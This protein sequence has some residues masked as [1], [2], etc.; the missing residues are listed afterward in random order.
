MNNDLE[1]NVEFS[2]VND[3]IESESDNNMEE[4]ETI[5]CDNCGE[6]VDINDTYELP[7]GERICQECYDNDYFTCDRCGE[8][9]HNDECNSIDSGNEYV[10]NDCLDNYYFCEDCQEY[11]SD[12]TWVAS[13][14]G[15]GYY[16]CDHCF[17]N[18]YYYYCE[19]CGNYYHEDD[20]EYDEDGDRYYCSTCY[21]QMCESS[22]SGMVMNY[23]AHKGMYARNILSKP[24]E[25]GILDT[26]YT[27]GTETEMENKDHTRDNESELLEVLGGCGLKPVFERDGSL[28]S[29]GVEM[30][31]MPYT[32][33]YLMEHTEDIKNAFT[34]AIELG[35]RADNDNCG[36]HI[37]VKRPSDEVVDRIWLIMETFKKE[38][39]AVARR[40]N[41]HY[42]HFISDYVSADNDIM[43]SLYYI[44]KHK[45]SGDRYYALN[46][47]NEKTIEFRI[48]K[49]TLNYR[50]WLAYQQFVHNII[51]E[52]AN[53]EKP[54]EDIKWEDLIVGEYISELVEKRNI[55]CYTRVVDNSKRIEEKE[56]K[57]N[58]IIEQMNKVLKKYAR[59]ILSTIKI[60]KSKFET[61]EDLYRRVDRFRDDTV[62]SCLNLLDS[63][64]S[65]E[66]C[67]D[68]DITVEQYITKVNSLLRNMEY[69]RDELKM[70]ED[71]INKVK[72]LINI[73][74]DNNEDMGGEE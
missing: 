61:I 55:V 5:V 42:A 24:E 6:V 47:T 49:G 36:I 68:S 51:T 19:E 21:E 34:K 18:G 23:H 30:I 11:V 40:H 58:E 25:V 32:Y 43:K 26:L 53:L 69:Y 48:F 3:N 14:G 67:K 65:L 54:V 29:T 66:K 9:H 62:Y 22:N 52:C 41:E 37:H 44:K 10:C 39:I 60:D 46:L 12:A 27:Q 8:I 28:N 73:S 13:L 74:G 50:T 1:L 15:S 33:D 70:S 31:T 38:I 17:N 59:Q 56:A 71:M 35:Y 2:E 64:R 63:L 4:N 20:M 57:R 7:N 16:V 72:E 45:N